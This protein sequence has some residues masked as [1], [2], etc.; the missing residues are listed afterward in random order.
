MAARGR[1]SGSIKPHGRGRG[2]GK[3]RQLDQECAVEKE[4]QSA[5]HPES[6]RSSNSGDPSQ[7]QT[8]EEQSPNPLSADNNGTDPLLV[9]L[10]GAIGKP[11]ENCTQEDFMKVHP[12]TSCLEYMI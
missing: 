5:T 12:D 10:L 11:P 8:H 6:E 1:R 9:A 4:N 3:G 7:V 2:R